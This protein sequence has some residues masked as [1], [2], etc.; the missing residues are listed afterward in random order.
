MKLKVTLHQPGSQSP[1][2]NLLVTADATSSAGDVALA[3]ARSS[4]F[5][6]H[7]PGGDLTLRILDT[8]S[9][10]A[11]DPH[12]SIV[13]SGLRSGARIELAAAEDRSRQA[14][15]AVLTVVEGPDKGLTMPLPSGSVTIGRA[16]DCDVR[17]SDPMVSKRHASLNIGRRV[18]ILDT[19]SAN[20]VVVGNVRVGR[21]SLGA[22]DVALLGETHLTVVRRQADSTTSTDV[23]F[24][25]SPRVLARPQAVTLEMPTPP[26]E[27]DKQRFPYLAL[28]MPLVMGIAFFAITRSPLS[29]IM[30][31][32][33]PIMLLGN[34]VDQRVQ[35][36]RKHTTSLGAFD[37]ELAQVEADLDESH[38]QERRQLQ[39]LYP[40]LE[41]CMKGVTLLNDLVWSRRPEHPEFLQVRLGT[42]SITPLTRI[43]RVRAAGMPEHVERARAVADRF[44]LLPDAPVVADLRS[45]GGVGFAG[46]TELVAGVARAVVAQTAIL[47]SPSELVIA[48]LTSTRRKPEWV[49]LEWLPHTSS[50][51]S[52]LGDQLLS[53]DEATGRLLLDRIEELIALRAQGGRQYARGPIDTGEKAQ[54]APIVPAVLIVADDASTDIARLTRIS[55]NGPDAGV[56]V[57]WVCERRGDIPGAARTF[58]DLADGANPQVG[59]VRTGTTVASVSCE[60]LDRDMSLT[61]ARRLAP[62]LD[63]GAPI[64]DDSDLPRA[65]PVVSVIGP[66]ASDDP[67]VVLTRWRENRTLI[68][69]DGS[70]AIPNETPASLRA[71]VG[72]TG[73]EPLA[74][75]LRVHGPHALVGG[76]T[77]AGKSEFLQA[78][79]LGLAHAMSPDRVAFL[80]V[81]YKGGAAF[82]R[83]VDLPHT[84]GLVTDLSPYLVRRALRSLRAELRH[85]EHMFNA[86]GVKD[87]IDFEKTGDPEC[88]PSLVI[89]VDEF[90]ALASEVPEFV[91]GV[92][93]VAQRGRSLGLHLILATQRP[94]GVIKDNLRANT[95]L[96]VALRMADEADSRDVLET[97][98][99]AHFDPSVPG[100]GAV[101]TGAGRITQ[102]QSAFPGSRTPAVPPASPIE[103]VEFDF[104]IG[105]P[106]RAPERRSDVS[107]LARDIDRIVET[108]SAAARIGGVPAPRKP[109]LKTLATSYSLELLKQRSDTE[110]VLGVMDD[111]D[112]QRQVTEYFRP[113]T[114]G[115]LLYVGAGG[116]GKTTA[117]RSLAL[118]AA[119]T[120]RS[121]PVHVYGLDFAGG[122]LGS[123]EPMPN[124]GS[125]I[126]GDD[127]ERVVRLISWLSDRIEDRAA[128]YSGVR[129]DTL[130]A[131]RELSGGAAEP[132][133]LVLL[134][135]FSAFRAEYESST[136]LLPTYQAFQ[137][138]LVDGR[139]VGIHFAVTADRP[140]AMPTSISTA[141]QRK[142]VLRLSEDDGYLAMGVP[143]DILSP[144]SP[145]GRCVQVDQPQEL[146]LAIL[147]KEANVAAQAR[148]TEE[149]AIELASLHPTRP[150]P[151][152]SLPV[153]IT[154]DELPHSLAGTPVLGV[155]D[156]TLEPVGFRPSGPLL[157]TGPSQSG[158]SS[159]VRWLAESVRRAHPS[160]PLVHLTGRPSPLSSLD[161]WRVTGTGVTDVAGKLEKLTE[162]V[163]SPAGD[164]PSIAIFVEYLT[165][166][167]GT[168]T[169]QP[170]ADLVKACRRNGQLIVGEGEAS[171]WGGLWSVITEMRAARTG[172]LLQPDQHDGESLL[173]T[174]LPRIRP[175]SNPPGRGFWV[176]GGKTLKVQVPLVE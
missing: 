153:V 100:R 114:D 34:Y 99:A 152:R 148:V 51:H 66:E 44:A 127:E 170:L 48:C 107:S 132:R 55:E 133:L 131:Y 119:I 7:T 23:R 147:G 167:V 82:A 25:R 144:A 69:R 1:E 19:N 116:S 160:V 79:V 56:Y 63:A 111:P 28:M 134:D 50:P 21:A 154:A 52:P 102:F 159:A 10:Q 80:F 86:K 98:M 146:Q 101:K 165:D 33:A 4:D 88:P 94:A 175:G 105:R 11:L 61:L 2:R 54:Q 85:R 162:I 70:P 12:Q 113:D 155:A 92:V 16:A 145:A 22:G 75:D 174:P 90:A 42:G 76:T 123:L 89:V 138:M 39:A 72:H 35:G 9:G 58:L 46:T 67:E 45:V 64:D 141:F 150:D 30:V 74:L 129:A 87:I 112:N 130:T 73:A 176:Q 43:D 128:R 31:A 49:W 8:D 171:T 97:P 15:A 53:S 136:L 117:L 3:L 77:G 118:A 151:I 47:H 60:S 139:A 169:E 13:D 38:A 17:L 158:R 172:L 124:V 108:V 143:R 137:R 163:S 5:E 173:R 135:G 41:T 93:D 104:G 96:R 26:S 142:V 122:G 6:G 27:H 32:L 115:N 29:L 126:N 81:D 166:F 37:A 57:M 59:M 84:V 103:I 40:G 109:W 106:W 36:R 164:G 120:P 110:I 62:M 68:P 71:L 91:D 20:G 24:T 83:C 161:L 157:L 78:W 125:I 149:L 95:N 140:A 156:A 121:G 14:S 65:V 18:E 168:P